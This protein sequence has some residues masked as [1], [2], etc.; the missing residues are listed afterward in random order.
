MS[1]LVIAAFYKFVDL[2]DYAELRAPLRAVCDANQ[3]KGTILLAQE[4]IN[5]TIAGPR[6]G[7]DAVLAYL[8]A[9]PR[10]GPLE[11]KE[12]SAD[13]PPFARMKVRLKKEIVTLG[14][15]EANPNFAVGNYVPPAE[16]N[17]LISDPSVTLVDTRNDYEVQVGTFKG[18]L[19]PQTASFREFPAYV[20]ANLDPQAHRKVAMFCTGGIRCE[21]ATALLLNLGF[22][23]VYHLEG[24]ILKYLET[25]PATESL[26]EGECFVFDERVTVDHALQRGSYVLDQPTGMPVKADDQES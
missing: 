9:D 12:A 10:I 20:E 7:I 24:G 8:Q 18:A 19:N 4:G 6:A 14:M 22:D 21:K 3:V 11:W 17:Q 23:E 26:W 13:T 16:W 15:P 2:P 5:S 1:T 25:V